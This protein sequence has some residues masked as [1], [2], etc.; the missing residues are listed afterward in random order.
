MLAR[1]LILFGLASA[2][3]LFIIM[4]SISPTSAGAFGILSVFILSYICI[5]SCT[6]FILFAVSKF[7]HR[8]SRDVQGA[9]R[10]LSLNLK[11]AYYYSS[12]ISLAPV[13]IISMQSVGGVG[14]YEM[15]LILLFVALGCVYVSRRLV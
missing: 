13:I 7:M 12:V 1:L 6:T 10:N 2:G 5:L 14:I 11:S 15:G 4:T 9:H 3:L 8:L